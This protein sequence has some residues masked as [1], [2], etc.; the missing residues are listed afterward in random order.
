MRAVVAVEFG[1]HDEDARVLTVPQR[2]WEAV[3]QTA[4]ES[5]YSSFFET[6]LSQF[7][8]TLLGRALRR[9]L[10]QPGHVKDE[11]REQIEQIAEMAEAGRGLTVSRR[12]EW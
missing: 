5:G 3:W 11:H 2:V 7:E 4:R 8:A 1:Q 12:T 10:E 6:G 9:A